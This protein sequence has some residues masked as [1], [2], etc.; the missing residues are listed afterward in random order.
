MLLLGATVVGLAIGEVAVRLSGRAPDIIPIGACSDRHVYRRSTNPILS[1][2]F[3]PG[4]RSDAKDLPFDY[5]AINSHGFRDVERQYAKPPGA[6]RIILLGDS[7]VVGYRIGQIDQLMSRQLEMLYGRE[8]VEVLNMAVT[9]YCTRSEV[10]LLRVRGVKYD[11]DIVILVFVENDFRNFNPESVGA[12]GF[13]GRS[14]VINGLFRTS[15]AFRLACVKLNWFDFGL[16]A[17]P[18]DW[19]QEAIGDN[20][21]ADGLALFR[22]LAD[23]YGFEPLVVVWPAF[24]TDG[25]EYP[26]KM[27]MPGS[28]EL[29]VE[30]LARMHGLPV[31]GLREP[32]LAH[33][34]LQKPQPIPRQYYTVGD[35]MH[36]SVEGNRVA[37][38]ILSAIVE[39]RHLLDRGG[40]QTARPASEP[41]RDSEAILA[42]R[43]RGAEK[44]GYGLV[45]YNRAV[46][47][48]RAGKLDAA[49]EQLE[50]VTSSDSI[51]YGNACLMMASILMERGRNAAA[52][53]RLRIVL[54]GNANHFEAD[55]VMA[56]LL[57]A[58]GNPGRAVEHLTRAVR[59]AP[60]RHEA[61]HLLGRA[62]G[63]CGRWQEALPHMVK[64]MQLA[65]GSVRVSNDL[66]AVLANLGRTEESMRQFRYSLRLDPGNEKA[67]RELQS[68][69]RRS[70]R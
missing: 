1:Y 16:E 51:A 41:G 45:Y 39:E 52:K 48:Y 22:E 37:A 25:I 47:L 12:D 18:A 10:E 50:K 29:I 56:G 28:D 38:E 67:R 30:R 2:E 59:A 4:Y 17:A 64:A 60:E 7:V 69:S 32:F 62:L 20:N 8:N 36:P 53:A 6:K 70:P 43:T 15:H 49:I 65:P 33:F 21:V 35:E 19:N 66:A 44:A 27:F 11:P 42:A 58:E 5:R 68:Q 24:T 54:E 31:A 55:M 26:A 9:G 57:T 23:Q 34:K 14:R 46:D 3:K 40:S 13:V 63:Q 61:H